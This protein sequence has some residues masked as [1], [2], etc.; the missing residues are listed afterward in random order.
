MNR[1]RSSNY[2]SSEDGTEK[3]ETIDV[4]DVPIKLLELLHYAQEIRQRSAEPAI[5]SLARQIEEGLDPC[6]SAMAAAVDQ[7]AE[8]A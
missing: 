2:S 8:V 6:I 7:L 5:Q 4:G 3:T 1:N